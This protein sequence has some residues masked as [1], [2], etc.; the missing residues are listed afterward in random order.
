MHKNNAIHGTKLRV[1]VDDSQR[2]RQQRGKVH[3][4]DS[5]LEQQR[6]NKQQRR[7]KPQFIRQSTAPSDDSGG[8]KRPQPQL[9]TLERRRQHR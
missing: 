2:R 8:K 9:R 7:A 3:S 1:A 5:V 4:V 6:Q